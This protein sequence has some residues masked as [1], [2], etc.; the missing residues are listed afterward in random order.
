LSFVGLEKTE[1]HQYLD[2]F[3]Q[4]VLFL[5]R[6]I[7]NPT[8]HPTPALY[9]LKLRQPSDTPVKALIEIESHDGRWRSVAVQIGRIQN[10]IKQVVEKEPFYHKFFELIDQTDKAKEVDNKTVI[11]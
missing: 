10:G 11:P 9:F 8:S 1:K 2:L 6:S 5:N 3:R 4:I 7:S